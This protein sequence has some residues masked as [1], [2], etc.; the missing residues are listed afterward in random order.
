MKRI[1]NPVPSFTNIE[2]TAES[3]GKQAIA[4]YAATKQKLMEWQQTQIIGLMARD[5]NGL[6]T[7]PDWCLSLSRRNGKGEILAAR[8]LWGILAAG[9]KILHTAHR[10]STSH[11]AYE[12]LYRLLIRGGMEERPRKKGKGLPGTFYASKQYGL[13]AII[14]YGGGE[15]HFRTRTD[16]GGLGEGF[17]VLVLDE[18][19]EYTSKQQ[20]A[21]TYTVSATKNPQTILVG[22]PPTA[23]SKGDVF[24]RI[25]NTVMNGTAKMVGWTEWSIEKLTEDIDNVDLWYQFNPSLGLILSERNIRRELSTGAVDFNVQRMGLWLSYKQDSAISP[26]EWDDVRVEDVPELE[27]KRFWGIKFGIDGTNVSMSVA[28]KTTD[29][30]VYVEHIACEPV[31]DGTDWMIEFLRN[32][33]TEKMAIDGASGQ[34]IMVD[35][36]KEAKIRK[37]PVLPTVKEIIA[38]N[39]LFETGL[40]GHLAHVEQEK[41]TRIVTN[42]EKRAI[43]SNGGFG[44]RSQVEDADVAIMDSMIL[45]YWLAATAKKQ[46]P[47]QI[48]Y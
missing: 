27:P 22:T 30:R 35:A 13:E 19:Q 4:L 5:D 29:G 46:A 32:P 33:K 26:K 36:I 42:C 15:I 40:Q 17:D 28:S 44:Y 31:R 21:L 47:Q 16:T 45:A 3:K 24:P 20:S 9:E 38:A 48:N 1:G 11:D 23:T 43:G 25:R 10:T 34:Q 2:P 8:E 14:V 39:A 7:Y 37:T 41:V 12:R 6:W 18:A